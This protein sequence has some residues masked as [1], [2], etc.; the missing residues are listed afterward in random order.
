[1]SERQFM[2]DTNIVSH[3]IRFPA[4]D[5]VQ[6]VGLAGV[7]K[8]CISALVASE[9]RYGAAKRASSRLSALVEDLIGRLD[10]LP[11]EASASP[12][13]AVIRHDLAMSGKLIGPVDLFIAAHAVSLDMT[14]V[15]DNVREFSRVDGLK[16]ENWLEQISP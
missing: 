6:R 13:Y 15:T 2:L 5:V 10:V 7:D 11:Y 9:L 16:I 1:V 3:M 4:G 14:L 8:I 12:S